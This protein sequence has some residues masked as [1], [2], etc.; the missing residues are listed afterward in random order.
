M[1]KFAVFIHNKLPDIQGNDK[2]PLL[3]GNV[4]GSIGF[5]SQQKSPTGLAP[6]HP[7]EYGWPA[8]AIPVT[9]A[10]WLLTDAGRFVTEARKLMLGW[11][12]ANNCSADRAFVW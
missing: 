4:V 7:A 6:M 10:S 8:S 11:L 1:D 9:F 2:A 12:V 5:C 3:K